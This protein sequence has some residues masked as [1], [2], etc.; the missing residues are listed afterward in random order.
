MLRSI[1]TILAGFII[2]S[3]LWLGSTTALSLI[4]PASFREDGSTSSV[5]ILFTLLLL[6]IIISGI[7]GY[8]VGWLAT[9]YA[10]R[11]AFDFR[12]SFVSCW[13]F[14]PNPILGC[15]TRVVS[16]NFSNVVT[17]CYLLGDRFKSTIVNISIKEC[18]ICQH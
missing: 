16:L 14:C 2:W 15:V 1:L 13:P 17:A 5:G 18:K 3:V 12:H 9:S 4:F 6:S 8:V 7:A 10:K 11:N